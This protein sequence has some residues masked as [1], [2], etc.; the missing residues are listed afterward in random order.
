MAFVRLAFFPG[1]TADHY[2]VLARAIGEIPA[3]AG[4][5][6]F[7]AGER[8][9]GW[10]LVQVWAS[11]DALDAFNR[12]VFFPALAAVGPG[13]FPAAP[14]VTDFDTADLSF[15]PENFAD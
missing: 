12:D 15:A 6:L 5:L 7:A 14:Q 2:G 11:R 13:G 3:P 1:G 9:G 10:Q 8:D 4:R